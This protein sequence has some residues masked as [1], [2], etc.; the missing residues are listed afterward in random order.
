M[1]FGIWIAGNWQLATCNLQ[2]VAAA[3]YFDPDMHWQNGFAYRPF[4][5][6][7]VVAR[8]ECIA[9]CHKML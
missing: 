4:A 5:F 9:Q 8:F 2:L 3:Q 1:C 7:I 6:H